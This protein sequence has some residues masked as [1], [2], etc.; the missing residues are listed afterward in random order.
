MK[1]K[2]KIV[3]GILIAVAL[4]IVAIAVNF[5]PVFEG[6]T[7][8]TFGKADKYHKSQMTEKD[9]QFRSELTADTAQL[10]KMLQGLIYFSVFT[11]ELSNKMD[12]CVT[13]FQQQGMTNQDTGFGNMLALQDYSTFIKNNNKTLGSTINLLSGFYFKDKADQS[14]DVEKN[15]REF[16]NYVKIL[17]E[18]DSILEVALRSMD[19]F[20]LNSKVLKDRK[21]EFMNLKSIRDQLLIGGLRLAALIDD[22]PVVSAICCYAATSQL[23]FGAQMGQYQLSANNMDQKQVAE[24]IEG[25]QTGLSGAQLCSGTPGEL[26]VML[27]SKDQLEIIFGWV[28]YDKENLQFVSGTAQLQAV[29]GFELDIHDIL[30]QKSNLEIVVVASTATLF[31]IAANLNLATGFSSFLNGANLNA[32]Q[33]EGLLNGFYQNLGWSAAAFGIL[34]DYIGFIVI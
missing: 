16:G 13:V 10:K 15:L 20:L 17:N 19:N 33:L 18:K 29:N 27:E 8:G 12:S 7:S 24:I 9:V 25:F 2:T 30:G 3:I 22:K 32:T 23:E 1:K 28:L 6:K 14:V 26:G 34:T 31:A 21:T 11:N 4:I 5:P